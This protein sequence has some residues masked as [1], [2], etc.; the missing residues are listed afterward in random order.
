M[1]FNGK[2][3]FK[4]GGRK[5]NEGLSGSCYVCGKVTGLRCPQTGKSAC[6]AHLQHSIA[7][8]QRSKVKLAA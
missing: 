5:M 8:A 7:E 6:S 4:A 2:G 1:F 3:F